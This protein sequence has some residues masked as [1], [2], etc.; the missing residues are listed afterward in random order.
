M[1]A[2]AVQLYTPNMA[3]PA[4]DYSELSPKCAEVFR[5]GAEDIR[6]LVKAT[7]AAIIEI[8]ERLLILKIM[9]LRHGQ[10]RDWVE[11]ECGFSLRSAERYMRAA[12]FVK[13]KNDTVSLLPPATL[14]AISAKDTSP[15]IVDRVLTMVDNG[16]VVDAAFLKEMMK[17]NAHSKRAALKSAQR[18]SQKSP[19]AQARRDAAEK[20]WQERETTRA[21]EAAAVAQTI[22]ERFGIEGAE[23]FSKIEDFH[24][25]RD[26]LADR[27]KAVPT[28]EVIDI[29][30]QLGKRDRG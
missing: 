9:E 11:A 21:Q 3:A 24:L 7:T 29:G 10:F 8:G 6:T 22:V 27:I 15:Q 20:R 16:E 1:P 26:A 13:D 28:A 30:P 14:Y 5:K 25:V 17:E 23:F 2:R 18:K 12:K 19:Q 4:F